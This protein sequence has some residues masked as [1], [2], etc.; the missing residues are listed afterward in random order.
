MNVILKD[1]STI[2]VTQRDID[3]LSALSNGNTRT[4]TAQILKI[5]ENT[6]DMRL[7]RL[8]LKLGLKTNY[9]LLAYFFRNGWVK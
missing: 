1:K 4:E 9:E 2:L 7:R 8:R 6:M 5:K 3:L